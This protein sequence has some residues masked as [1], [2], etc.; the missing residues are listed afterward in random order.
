MREERTVLGAYWRDRPATAREMIGQTNRFVE[1]LQAFHPLFE[2]RCIVIEDQVR[3]LPRDLVHFEPLMAEYLADNAKNLYVNP[4]PAVTTF[5]LDSTISCGFLVALSDPSPDATDENAAAVRVI[6]GAGGRLHNSVV[7]E[8]PPSAPELRCGSGK[9]VELMDLVVEHWSPYFGSLT[10]YR[11]AS[12]LDPDHRHRFRLGVLNY[13]ASPGAADR[14]RTSAIVESRPEGTVVRFDTG[15]PFSD[16]A[17]RFVPCFQRL[18]AAGFLDWPECRRDHEGKA[19]DT[20]R[21]PS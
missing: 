7:F 19:A 13:L 15:F 17:D 6:A 10:S 3:I 9:A 16:A 5:T 11:L 4:D 1:A 12:K 8:L 2:N 18:A 14:C 20:P 21:K